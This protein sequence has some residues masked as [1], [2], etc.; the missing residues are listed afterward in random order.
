M[1][2]AHDYVKQAWNLIAIISQMRILTTAGW[3]DYELLDSGSG[4]RLERFGSY[5]L[6]RPDPQALWKTH[7]PPAAW[8]KA[9]ARY[10]EKS[11]DK[12]AWTRTIEMPDRWL[13]HWKDLSI[14]C[15]LTA[16]KHTGVFPEQSLNWEWIEN[17][18]AAAK[19]E[20]TV[21]NL[22]GYTGIASLAAARGGARVTHVDAS[23]PAIAWARE[24]QLASRL[25]DKP[26]RWI[27]DDALKFV[28]REIRRGNRYDGIILDPPV[29]GH[30]PHGEVWNFSQDFPIIMEACRQ[31]L[32]DNPLFI[33]V[34]A[35]A[36]SMSAIM[37]ENVLADFIPRG[38]IEAGEL[39]IEEK[40]SKRLLSTGIFGRWSI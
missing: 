17:Q 9:S 8:E 32:S 27:A 3:E 38:V 14:W 35:Y 23:Q 25:V 39:A 12:G 1:A 15:K 33:L 10:D 22:F 28:K 5:S 36:V 24:N 31:I 34:N 11:E 13:I 21:L 20:I 18:I 7:L 19:R 16:F 29:Y 40:N 26:I 2:Q 37:L 30:G 4:R 6:S